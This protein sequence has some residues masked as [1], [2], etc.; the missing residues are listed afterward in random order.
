MNIFLQLPSAV[1]AR[2]V[3]S[4]VGRLASACMAQDDTD[5]RYVYIEDFGWSDPLTTAWFD[6]QRRLSRG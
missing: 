1:T 4:P 3:G 6:E 2:S 5:G